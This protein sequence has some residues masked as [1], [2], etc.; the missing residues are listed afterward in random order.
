MRWNR[1]I[2]ARQITWQIAEPGQ[3]EERWAGLP[4]LSGKGRR[5]A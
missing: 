5:T 1:H 3:T 2:G 4:N